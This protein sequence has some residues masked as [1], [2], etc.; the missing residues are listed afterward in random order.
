MNESFKT[1]LTKALVLT[2]SQ[3]RSQLYDKQIFDTSAS[4]WKHILCSRDW[5]N[6]IHII[7]SSKTLPDERTD[8]IDE[9]NSKTYVQPILPIFPY[10]WIVKN[11]PEGRIRWNHDRLGF[12]PPNAREAI[13]F[14]WG[15]FRRNYYLNGS[16]QCG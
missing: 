5:R 14:D 8:A 1:P 13:V 7:L 12:Y 6:P 2:C 4:S 10:E 16:Y 9:V 11:W 15:D 3:W